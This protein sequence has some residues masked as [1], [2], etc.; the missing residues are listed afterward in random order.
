MDETTSLMDNNIR[1]MQKNMEGLDQLH[2][3]TDGLK[4]EA[5]QFKVNAVKVK[6]TYWWTNCK[7]KCF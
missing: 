5:Q 4:Q 1:T 7:V 6:R 3:K 2:E